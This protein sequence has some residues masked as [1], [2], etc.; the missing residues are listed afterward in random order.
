MIKHIF[1]N[2]S[3][4]RLRAFWR[5]T[6][7][8][9]LVVGF[10]MVF[11]ILISVFGGAVHMTAVLMDEPPAWLLLAGALVMGVSV[12]LSVLVA[13]RLLDRRPLSDFGFHFS[14][15]WWLDLLFGLALGAILM[16]GI[17][18][19]Q[20][21]MGW[22]RITGFLVSISP[23]LPFTTGLLQTAMLFLS[24]GIYEEL[25]ARGYQLRNLAEGLNLR[26]IGP[27]PALILG[28]VFSSAVFGLLHVGNPHASI[29]STFNIFIAGLFFG[30][31]YLLTGELAIPIGLHIAWNFFQGNVFGFPVSGTSPIVSFIAIQQG[32]AELITGGAFGPEAGLLG[33]LAMTVGS[34]LTVWWVRRQRG[35]ATLLV[36]LAQYPRRENQDFEP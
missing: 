14:R 27:R 4:R 33:L 11:G 1:W 12:I 3:E 20:W 34:L 28:W 25:F 32:G 26:R 5:L 7:Q 16:L 36:K 24:V 17:F 35:S 22:V 6:F 18:L 2:S 8:L 9:V 15:A 13:G 30:L 10:L 21:G 19:L 31:A 23:D 29:L